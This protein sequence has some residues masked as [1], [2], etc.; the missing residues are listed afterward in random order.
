[1]TV[2]VSR[3][4]GQ[5]RVFHTTRK[6]GNLP[7]NP[8]EWTRE[9]AVNWGLSECQECMGGEYR[10]GGIPGSTHDRVVSHL[11]DNG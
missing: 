2:Y 11:E 8:Q 7:R 9:T 1:M 10:T 3:A 6:C 5:D 4:G